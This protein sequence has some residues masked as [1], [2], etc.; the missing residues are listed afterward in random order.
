MAMPMIHAA[1][2]GAAWLIW[3][4]VLSGGVSL[5]GLWATD[6]VVMGLGLRSVMTT[7]RQA[8]S[9]VPGER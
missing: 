5:G 9:A 8:T 3:V 4:A 7:T 6:R 2:S 1:L